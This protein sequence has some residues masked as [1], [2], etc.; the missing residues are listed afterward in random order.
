MC[1]QT[2]ANKQPPTARSAIHHINQWNVLQI[3]EITQS[4]SAPRGLSVVVVGYPGWPYTISASKFT[5]KFQH[6]NVCQNRIRRFG[7]VSI[8][9][10]SSNRLPPSTERQLKY[11][12]TCISGAMRHELYETS[13]LPWGYLSFGP[14]VKYDIMFFVTSACARRTGASARGARVA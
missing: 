5:A 6:K 3:M 11:V 12:S 1:P 13:Q 4:A 7:I 10:R 2:T 14:I 9:P 8:R